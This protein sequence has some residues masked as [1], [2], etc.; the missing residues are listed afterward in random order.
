MASI[1]ENFNQ[2]ILDFIVDI[3]TTFPEH[4]H[5]LEKWKNMTSDVQ[6]TLYEYISQV[7]PERFFDILYQNTEI[8][9]NDEINTKFLPELDFKVLYNDET[10]SDNTRQVLWKYL[11]LILFLVVGNIKDKSMFGESANIFD[12]IE[13]D[14]L[15]NKLKETMDD[16][17]GFFK[18]M[19]LNMDQTQ[20][21][22]KQSTPE[23]DASS[24]LP[25]IENLQDHLKSLFDGK[26]GKLAKDLAEEISTDFSSVLGDFG[27]I[28]ENNPPSTNDIL[29]KLMKNP[30]KIMDLVKTVG[31]KIKSKMDDGEINKEDLMGEAS[32]ILSKM[33]EMGGTDEMNEILKKFAGSM[34][35]NMKIDK[36]ALNRMSKT[37]AMKERMRQK[38]EKKQQEYNITE[39]EG[40][41]KFSLVDEDK[42]ER[43]TKTQAQI[44][45]ELIASFVEPPVVNKKSKKSKKKK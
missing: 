3:E 15:G 34:G 35:K 7:Y 39:E 31:S 26:I 2:T 12:G 24:G 11:Q 14:E 23:C 20:E 10:V 32:E 1:P 13:E 5:I 37:E 22:E 43:S 18:N 38:L 41:K 36:N 27:E 16:L 33:K 17:G 19:G 40:K 44:D 6:Q 8:F 45:E 28:D 4:T 29:K 42:Q 9:Q 25:N 21:E 30:K